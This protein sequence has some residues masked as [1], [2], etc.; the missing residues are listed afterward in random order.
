M[1]SEEIIK[2]FVIKI[3]LEVLPYSQVANDLNIDRKTLSELERNNKLALKEMA[4]IRQIYIRKKFQTVTPREF[5]AWYTSTPRKC[6][7]CDFTEEDIQLLVS[8]K[9]IH[10]KRLST[11]GK[12][13][14][15]ERTSPNLPYDRLDNLVYCC[16]W[17]NNAKTDEFSAAEFQPI[18]Q[19]LKMIWSRRIKAIKETNDSR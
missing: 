19:V 4:L 13:L 12:T 2:E 3:A 7:Y 6:V 8:H 5:L 14:E 11:R 9:Q 1:P 18:G 17:C 10:T 15:I 16:Y